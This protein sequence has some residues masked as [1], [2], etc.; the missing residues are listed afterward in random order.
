MMA[1]TGVAYFLIVFLIEY[2]RNI[3]SVSRLLNKDVNSK[4]YV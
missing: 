1:I 4:A 3:Q 2:L